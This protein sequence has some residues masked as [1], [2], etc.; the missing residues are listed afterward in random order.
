MNIQTYPRLKPPTSTDESG[1]S[2][3]DIGSTTATP[4]DASVVEM[5]DHAA[6][7]EEPTMRKKATR[8]RPVTLPPNHKTSP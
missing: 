8:V 2:A 1:T 6:M 3:P 4:V 5:S 7:T